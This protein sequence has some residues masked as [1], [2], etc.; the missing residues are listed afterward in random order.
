[1]VE[2]PGSKFKWGILLR[3]SKATIVTTTD[4]SRVQFEGSTDRQ[5]WELVHHIEENGKGEIVDIYKDIASGWKPGARRTRFKDALADLEAGRIHGIAVLNIDRLTRQIGQVRPILNALQQM[6]GRLFSLEDELD[7]ADVGDPEHPTELRLM[8]LVAKAEREARR[9]SERWKLVHKHRVI[10]GLPHR[11]GLRPFGHE[12]STLEATVPEEVRL[13]QAAAKAIVSGEETCYSIAR[14]WTKKEIPTSSGGPWHHCTVYNVLTSPRMVGK[15]RYGDALHDL[16]DAVPI[17]AEELWE[18]VC[19]KLARNPTRKRQGRAESYEATGIALCG[20]CGLPLASN[21]ERVSSGD[22]EAAYCCRK[23]PNV[24]G[25]C[26]GVNIRVRLLDEVL[27]TELVAFINDR[28]RVQAALDCY[29][30]P[31]PDMEAIEERF[32]QLEADKIRLQKAYFRPPKGQPRLSEEFYYEQLREIAAE[33]E[34]LSHRRL[35]NR[36]AEP[37]RALLRR[38]RPWTIEEW[39]NEP[40]DWRR[41]IIKLVT[42]RIEVTR[43]S[44]RGG[45][46]KGMKGGYFDRDRVRIKFIG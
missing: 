15:R 30:L 34:E 33:Q 6:G 25:A 41:G 27:D 10:K 36:E 4:G 44:T 23:R 19:A 46:L 28:E 35:I 12:D 43:S 7:T 1:M 20:D 8:E 40:L 16:P 31:T 22:Y 17:L 37:L 18:Q 11:G 45:S 39:R 42:E 26:G 9:T 29:R 32:A 13:I 3:K 38:D 14:L 2:A 5:E 21:R 24:P